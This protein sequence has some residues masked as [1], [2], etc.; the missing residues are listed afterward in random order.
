MLLHKGG[1][2]PGTS[3]AGTIIAAPIASNTT[4]AISQLAMRN[5]AASDAGPKEPP[6]QQAGV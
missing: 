6:A 1:A 2:Y 5:A 4:V 3:V